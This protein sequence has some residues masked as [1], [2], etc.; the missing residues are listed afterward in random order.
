MQNNMYSKWMFVDKI[1]LF[2]QNVVY[3][4]I[5]FAGEI[6]VTMASNSYLVVLL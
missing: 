1:S 6:Q 4:Q 3:N 5:K 2:Q